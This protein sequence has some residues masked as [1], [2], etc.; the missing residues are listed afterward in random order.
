MSRLCIPHTISTPSHLP[1]IKLVVWVSHC[2]DQSL[3]SKLETIIFL[4]YRLPSGSESRV[5]V[6]D[7]CG[8]NAI[9]DGINS[10]I[11]I[12]ECVRKSFIYLLAVFHFE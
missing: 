3:G 1:T 9:D 11:G 2:D 4:L 5:T 10:Q 8:Y 7:V 12:S 6:S